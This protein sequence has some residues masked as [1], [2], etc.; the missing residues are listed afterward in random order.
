[1]NKQELIKEI[2]H[3]YSE[4]EKKGEELA[5]I[6]EKE[7][8]PLIDSKKYQEA[9]K[10]VY[11]FYKD[12]V[13]KNGDSIAIEAAWLLSPVNWSLSKKILRNIRRSERVY[14]IGMFGESLEI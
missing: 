5:A 8:E 3:L 7:I 1:M 14:L 6:C 10:Y 9:K 12:C 4:L 13:D 11:S 2:I